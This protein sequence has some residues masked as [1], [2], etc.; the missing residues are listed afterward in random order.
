MNIRDLPRPPRGYK[1]RCPSQ[2][3]SDVRQKSLFLGKDDRPFCILIP[4][5]V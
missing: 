4:V 3:I 2:N 1:W 5:E